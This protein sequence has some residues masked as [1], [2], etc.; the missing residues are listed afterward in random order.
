VDDTSSSDP[1]PPPPEHWSFRAESTA[2]PPSGGD[3]AWVYNEIDAFVVSR[4]T[5]LG[6][7]P[8]APASAEKLMRRVTLT[9]TGLPP[10]LQELDA[11]LA[12]SSD[13]AYEALVDRLLASPRYAEHMASQ[14]LDLARYADTDGY[15]YDRER[16]VWPWRDWVIQAFDT[17]M[18]FDEFTLEQLAGDL[19]PNA[20]PDNILATA[21]NRNHAI[22]NENG[23]LAN[24]FR[25]R[26]VSDRV[27]ALGKTWLGL[28]VGCAKCHNHRFD[29]TL[30]TD[31][32]QLYDCFNQLDEK[33]NGVTSEF[34]PSM[35]IPSPYAARLGAELGERLTELSAAGSPEATLAPVRR[36]ADAVA[37]LVP[38]R[39]MQDQSIRRETRLLAQGRYDLPVGDPLKC[40]APHFLPPF[41]EDAP[42][43]RLGLAK[44]LVMPEHPLTAR[45]TVNRIWHQHWG[46]GLLASL[47][48]FG[49]QAEAPEYQ[50]LLD[51]LARY[52]IDSGW[53]VKG[54]HR[55]I[56]TSNTYRQAS[57]TDADRLEADPDNEWLGRGPRFRL[58]AEVIRDLPLAASGL[59]VQ[60][61]GG[62]PAWPYQ[63]AGLWEELS[64]ES[65]L[66]SY[67][68]IEGDGL[69]RRSLYSFWKRTLPPPFMS[70][71]DAPDRESSAAVRELGISPQQALALLNGTQ[72]IEAA[73]QLATRLWAADSGEPELAIERGFRLLT[74][75]L[76]SEAEL[77]ILM[78][79]YQDQLQI[80]QTQ[81]TAASRLQRTGRSA[82][83][84]AAP[85]QVA[86]TQV[87]RVLFNLSETIT[88]E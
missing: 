3:Q 35:P 34:S 56:V 49:R 37:A 57:I 43:N 38:A 79:L 16:E 71:F 26:Y 9:L 50:P 12:D 61:L 40:S 73:R 74:S 10:S 22:Q 14:W 48:N 5:S 76:P 11:F 36:D 52:F 63:P 30:A 29:P 86:L 42:N 6:Q 8:A 25:D 15:Q 31:Y 66:L 81:G 78:D 28:T 68:A 41:P 7:A 47:D 32:Y 17:N 87:V 58:S 4:L 77:S 85:Q 82:P 45:V 64:W 2:L 44:W 51:W 27:D 59:L 84:S 13:A 23:L 53:D 20:T 70:L 54:L 62:P 19:L 1:D 33:D 80:A 65:Y 83:S 60:R 18:P 75:R 67:P 24:E 88:Q 69:Y 55:L 46:R 39:I 21:F 72:F